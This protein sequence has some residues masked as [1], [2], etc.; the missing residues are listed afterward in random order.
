MTQRTTEKMV[1][2]LDRREEAKKHE[3]VGLKVEEKKR[4]QTLG[5][6]WKAAAATAT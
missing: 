1:K 2:R 6:C 5:S 3:T 4:I